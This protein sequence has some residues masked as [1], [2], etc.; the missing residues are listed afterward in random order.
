M[1]ILPPPAS[2]SI[3]GT[4]QYKRA[5]FEQH[6]LDEGF[7]RYR[8]T[9]GLP[10]DARL[11]RR[12]VESLAGFARERGSAFVEVYPAGELFFV[13]PPAIVGP[14]SARPL[15]GAARS[16]YVACIE[17]AF[18]C[19]H[20]SLIVADDH[21]LLD[22]E[23]TELTDFDDSL[24][25]DPYVFHSEGDVI[26]MIRCDAADGSFVSPLGAGACYDVRK[27][28]TIGEA[29]GSLL[30]PQ[31]PHFGHWISQFL[32]KYVTARRAG[33]LPDVPVLISD[34]IGLTLRDA[35]AAF[36]PQSTPVIE[37]SL[38]PVRVQRLW[39]APTLW[40]EPYFEQ[41]NAR[42]P[43]TDHRCFPAERFDEMLAAMAVCADSVGRIGSRGERVYLARK[44]AA[45]RSLINDLEIQ[46]VLQKRD[47]AVVYPEDLSFAEQIGCIRNARFIVGPEGS[48]QWLNFFARAGTRLCVLNH[49]YV[50]DLMTGTYLW[51]RAGEDVTVFT[52]SAI[53]LND[54]PEYP[55]LGFRQYADFEID[56]HAF[57][58][59]LDAWL[60]V[61][62]GGA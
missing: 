61:E 36:L 23:G 22:V 51:E 52:G 6:G 49:P 15:V 19:A 7:R 59:F 5:L 48:Q 26:W 21:V 20:S 55:T 1:S 25:L 30:G 37:V 46:D 57:A 44:P 45:V 32:P 56:P 12:R 40:Y 33:R 41:N 13:R 3:H 60:L 42:Y 14:N 58:E 28:A 24:E 47:F 34:H 4:L 39:V 54:E 9:L 16:F 31:A 62:G 35:L 2:R 53:R 38:R 18:V 43:G 11:E 29:F 27:V 17:D 50:L 8:D 10:S